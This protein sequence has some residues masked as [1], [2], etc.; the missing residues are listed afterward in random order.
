MGISVHWHAC[1]A[2]TL[3][4]GMVWFA[5]SVEL[6]AG[7]ADPKGQPESALRSDQ[8]FGLFASPLSWGG[9]LDKWQGVQRKLD[10][11]GVQL[12]LCDGDREGCVSPA[13]LQ[14]LT[15]VDKSRAREGRARLGEINRATNLAIRPMSDL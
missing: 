9:V 11:E 15:I 1:R 7:T 5:P 2:V 8:P 12:A 4:L 3:A 13:A 14:L 6:A 10:E